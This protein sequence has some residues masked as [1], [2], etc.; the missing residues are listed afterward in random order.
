LANRAPLGLANLNNY[1]FLPRIDRRLPSPPQRPTSTT[2]TQAGAAYSCPKPYCCPPALAPH[3]FTALAPHDPTASTCPKPS[4][5]PATAALRPPYAFEA[6][7][8]TAHD[9]SSDDVSAGPPSPHARANALRLGHV[10]YFSK[11]AI[12]CSC[13]APPLSL[14]FPLRKLGK[15]CGVLLDQKRREHL[16]AC[17]RCGDRSPDLRLGAVTGCGRPI[18][19]GMPSA[20]NHFTINITKHL[21]P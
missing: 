6:K 12:F 5:S 1:H 3:D 7:F 2:N 17:N 14:R 15:T 13:I 16:V 4:S 20:Q 18:N 8:P 19:S 9:A 10:P 21:V 11:P